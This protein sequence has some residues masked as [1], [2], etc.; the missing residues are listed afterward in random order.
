MRRCPSCLHPLL[1]LEPLGRP[2]LV[3]PNFGSAPRMASP[4]SGSAGRRPVAFHLASTSPRNRDN[5]TNVD[6]RLI[7]LPAEILRRPYGGRQL[8]ISPLSNYNSSPD[9]A[10]R[11]RQAAFS[12]D[13]PLV[14]IPA[15]PACQIRPPNKEGRPLRKAGPLSSCVFPLLADVYPDHLAA[16]D[17]LHPSVQLSS[18]RCAV[19]R[20]RVGLAH[21]HRR[22][23]LWS[24]PLCN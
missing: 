20:N 11:E 2:S 10:E 8:R 9:R 19:I 1:R 16:D 18:C 22:D 12:S 3:W 7:R 23:G 24:Q 17:D 14:Q 6:L 15:L 4:V 21:S 13:T 5:T